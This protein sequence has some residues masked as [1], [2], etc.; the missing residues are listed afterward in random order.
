M[1]NLVN[2]VLTR[3]DSVFVFFSCFSFFPFPIFYIYITP[4]LVHTAVNYLI[5]ESFLHTL[6]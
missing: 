4:A 2:P 1:Y 5:A 6:F 3:A